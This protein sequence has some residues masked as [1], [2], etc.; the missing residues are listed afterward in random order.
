MTSMQT[1]IRFEPLTALSGIQ[2]DMIVWPIGTE[3]IKKGNVHPDL[4]SILPVL[5][6]Q[7][8][9]E[10]KANQVYSLPVGGQFQHKIIM[11]VGLGSRDLQRD[12]IRNAAQASAKAAIKLKAGKVAWVVP[13]SFEVTTFSEHPSQ[14]CAHAL[15][16]GFLYGTYRIKKY[17]R[18]QPKYQGISELIYLREKASVDGMEKVWQEG[19]LSGQIYAEA[20]NTARDLTNIPGNLLVPSTLAE[21]AMK[22]ARANQLE[23]FV[24]D[25]QQIQEM[26]MGGLLAVGQGSIHP[27]RMIVLKYQGTDTWTNVFGLVGKGITFDTG[28]ISLKK[29]LGMEEM[30][31]DMGGAATV[32]GVMQAIA[33]L[34]PRINVVAVIPSAEN[35][36]SSNA[37]KPGDIITT[38]SGRTIEILNTDAEGR[39]VLADGMT[40]AKQLGAQ[41]FIDVATLTGAVLVTLADI[42]TGVVTNDETFLQ[43]F[44]AAS[45][46]T[47]EKVWPLPAY[48]EFW[49]MLKSDV[50]DLRNRTGPHGAAS[51]AGLFIGTFADGLPWIHLDIAG[52]AFMMRERGIGSK[53][54]SGEMVRTI[55]EM[56]MSQE[57]Q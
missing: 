31:S 28:G 3:Q 25:E 10:A 42:A 43:E 41:K 38:L 4:D 8:L 44:I 35:M 30:I 19:V 56:F 2:A 14:S 7:G 1:S 39:V 23:G 20:T 36:P 26:G 33:K 46:K 52:T 54:A 47:G 40:Y 17:H 13:A 34:R 29:G 27:P 32:L 50:A 18:D 53:G 22:I 49:D 45:K 24:L 21:E 11:L 6:S 37:F 5:A 9:F 15:T 16:E 48:E 57:D 51:T 12:T 55:T